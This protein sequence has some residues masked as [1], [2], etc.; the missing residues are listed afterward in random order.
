MFGSTFP[1]LKGRVAVV[2]G[3]ADGVA[4]A[5]CR[6]LADRGARVA[7]IGDDETDLED[8][9]DEMRWLGADAI[10]ILADGAD[11]TAMA[12]V[13]ASVLTEVGAPELLFVLTCTARAG[14][15][16]QRTVD[17]GLTAT[18][19]ALQAFVPAMAA[20]R[21][22]AVVTLAPFGPDP[23]TNA[24]GG[25]VTALTQHYARQVAG[26]RVL[27]TAVV[28]GGRRRV[29]RPLPGLG[30]R[31]AYDGNDTRRCGH[32]DAAVDP[33]YERPSTWDSPRV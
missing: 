30:R 2:L 31:R 33:M 17:S 24:V 10:G 9:I 13:R 7:V 20:A 28:P 6:M 19:Q 27:D 18:F 22:G 26:T 12:A 3:P 32:T 15:D 11:A 16:W 23:A 29:R 1:E 4:A 8:L 5:V 21:T 25:G 14:G